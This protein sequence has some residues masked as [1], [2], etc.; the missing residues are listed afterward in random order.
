MRCQLRGS[1]WAWPLLGTLALVVL[2]QGSL[3]QCAI[4]DLPKLSNSE[5]E[6]HSLPPIVR[7]TTS[8]VYICKPGFVKKSPQEPDRVICLRRVWMLISDPCILAPI[9]PRTSTKA[10]TA[11][12]SSETNVLII[13]APPPSEASLVITPSP[14]STAAPISPRNSTEETTT[15]ASSVTSL[16][17]TPSPALTG[18][19]IGILIAGPV[20]L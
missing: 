13:P 18:M 6:K 11:P 17:I 12:A 5:P 16:R 9:P 4:K 3:G 14:P 10:T 19:F 1:W 15:P 7:S 20:M 2:P 8:V